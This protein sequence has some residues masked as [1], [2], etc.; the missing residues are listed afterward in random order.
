MGCG[1]SS[2]GRMLA[3]QMRRFFVDTDKVIEEREEMTVSDIF[4]QKGEAYFRELERTLIEEFLTYSPHVMATGGGTFIQPELREKIK[5]E[6]IVVWLKAEYDVLLERV[7]RKQTRPILEKGDKAEILKQL[8]DERY[9]IYAEAD[10]V[11]QSDSGPHMNVVEAII[12]EIETR[13]GTA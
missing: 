10:I 3:S 11:I 1:K 6:T 8:M 13:Y 2:I 4:E 12:K 9:P 7:S 5:S